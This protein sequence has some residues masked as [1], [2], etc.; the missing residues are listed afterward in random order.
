VA[1]RASIKAEEYN[2]FR[3]LVTLYGIKN[4]TTNTLHSFKGLMAH[5]FNNYKSL[6]EKSF[7]CIRQTN[8][9]NHVKDSLRNIYDYIF[10]LQNSPKYDK[11]ES[12]S[13]L[14]K[15][16]FQT[17]KVSNAEHLRKYFNLDS[18]A[19]NGNEIERIKRVMSFVHNTIPH[20]G[21]HEV[22]P[23]K[24]WEELV[25]K[26]RAAGTGAHCG[27]LAE[28]LADCYKAIGIPAKR[29]ICLP[30]TYI[31]DCHSIVSVWD[32]DTGKWIWMDPTNEAYVMDQQGNALGILEVRERLIDNL[33]L[34]INSDAN[35]NH[36][37]S[38]VIE[39]YI[40]NYMAKNL[41]YLKFFVLE[42]TVYLAPEGEPPANIDI[43][44]GAIIS[45]NDN[46]FKS[47]AHK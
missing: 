25:K 20:D 29:V 44:E 18:V 10:I 24:T 42:H 39:D 30:K 28:L 36:K 14:N 12:V 21:N 40:Y 1:E 38:V 11:T 17:M 16:D 23:F 47:L 4:D 19:G 9:F 37:S 45:H 41:Y 31:N 2:A 13:E 34:K 8:Y 46:F 27:I 43:S 5:G 35:W 32:K 7:N 6:E 3:F 33:P 22:P 26:T 15:L